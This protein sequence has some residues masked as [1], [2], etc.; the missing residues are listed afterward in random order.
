MGDG[1]SLVEAI[2]A[3][4]LLAGV[5]ISI[6]GLFILGGK[7]LSSGRNSTEALSVARGILEEMQGWGF[8][9]TWLAYGIDGT[10][11]M[12]ATVDTRT[13]G[14]ASKWQPTL[15]DKLFNGYGLIDIESLANGAPP[16]LKNTRFIRVVVTI[17]WSEGNRQRQI[18][19]GT[20]R[21]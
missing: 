19:L 12:A 1:F 6:A 2:I 9:Q 14:Y 20:V 18:R 13:N 5:L 11:Q 8:Q 10:T 21:M 17:F 15:D 16:V 4:G 3:L 7:Q